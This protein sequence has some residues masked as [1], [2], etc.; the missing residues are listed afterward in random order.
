MIFV[1][2]AVRLSLPLS[3]NT[4]AALSDPLG[5]HYNTLV[6]GLFLPAYRGLSG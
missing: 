5:H 6:F 1:L 2:V 3:R 4:A